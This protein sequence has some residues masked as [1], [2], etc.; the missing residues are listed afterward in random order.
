M[1]IPKMAKSQENLYMHLLDEEFNQLAELI[2]H[3][4]PL[5]AKEPLFQDLLSIDHMSELKGEDLKAFKAIKEQEHLA[6]KAL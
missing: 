5:P 4:Q 6:A 2:I 3:E 1:D